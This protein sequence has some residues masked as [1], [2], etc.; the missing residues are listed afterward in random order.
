VSIDSDMTIK[1]DANN[2]KGYHLKACALLELGKIDPGV[3]RLEEGINLL[4]RCKALKSF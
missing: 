1:L 3:E 2:Y 4:I